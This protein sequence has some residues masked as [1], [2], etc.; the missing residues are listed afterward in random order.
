MSYLR[1]NEHPRPDSYTYLLFKKVGNYVDVND[2][3]QP[4]LEPVQIIPCY[5]DNGLTGKWDKAALGEEYAVKVTRSDVKTFF[6]YAEIKERRKALDILSFLTSYSNA[7][8]VRDADDLESLDFQLRFPWDELVA[9]YRSILSKDD[10]DEN[11]ARNAL[12]SILDTYRTGNMKFMVQEYLDAMRD[13]HQMSVEKASEYLHK[14]IAEGFV[15]MTEYF[16]IRDGKSKEYRDSHFET[17]PKSG[18]W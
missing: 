6:D 3:V 18:R 10:E 11:K 5:Y 9:N 7:G 8:A 2:E 4:I 14:F 12:M 15:T 13:R 16:S 1:P 17:T